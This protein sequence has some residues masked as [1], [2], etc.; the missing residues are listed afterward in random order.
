MLQKSIQGKTC[1]F[2]TKFCDVVKTRDVSPVH[3]GPKCHGIWARNSWAEEGE[4]EEA[5]AVAE[6]EEEEEEHEKTEPSPGG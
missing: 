1:C 4:E 3:T 6:E 5:E 2:A